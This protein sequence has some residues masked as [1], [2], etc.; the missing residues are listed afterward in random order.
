MKKQKVKLNDVE[1]EINSAPLGQIVDALGIIDVLAED[2]TEID[3]DNQASTVRIL[4]KML[5]NSSDELFSMIGN[6]AGLDKEIIAMLSLSELITLIRVILEV[7]DISSIKKEFGEITKL[8][9]A[10][11]QKEAKIQE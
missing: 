5:K 2:I 11:N 7:N 9:Q 1:Y 8:F 10:S 4:T 6:I 3:P